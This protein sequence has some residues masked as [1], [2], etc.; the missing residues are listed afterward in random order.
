MTAKADRRRC[1]WRRAA[2]MHAQRAPL[3][4]REA[5]EVHQHDPLRVASEHCV[6]RIQR[7][8]HR[9]RAQRIL[10]PGTMLQSGNC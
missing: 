2:C 3:R 8:Q 6:E 9:Q 1:C 7:Q 4:G 10:H 5:L